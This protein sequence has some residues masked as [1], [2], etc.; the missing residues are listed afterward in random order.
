MKNALLVLFEKMVCG[1]IKTSAHK[2]AFPGPFSRSQTLPSL[3]HTGAIGTAGGKVSMKFHRS[4]RN[5]SS[6]QSRSRSVQISPKHNYPVISSNS[7]DSLFRSG[8]LDRSLSSLSIASDMGKPVV[9]AFLERNA[10][11]QSQLNKVSP[12]GSMDKLNFVN[13]KEATQDDEYDTNLSE[14]Q[15]ETQ[16]N[17]VPLSHNGKNHGDCRIGP[18]GSSR[19]RDHDE[20]IQENNIQHDSIQ[21][22]TEGGS[23]TVMEVTTPL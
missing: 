19:E 4:P 5:T 15:T 6:E 17:V 11:S 22:T 1:L 13:K 3:A 20:F 16:Q 23:G 9:H 8:A 7:R 2:E 12:T 18:A 14:S 21:P 10:M